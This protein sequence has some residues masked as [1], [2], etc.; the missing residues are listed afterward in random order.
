MVRI[1]AE[2]FV[3]DA[4]RVETRSYLGSLPNEAP[5]RNEAARSPWGVEN[6][7]PWVLDVT[8]HE[9]CSRSKKENAPEHFGLLRRL[10]LCLLKPE[11]SSKRSIKGKRLRASWD[12]GYLLQVLCGNA[13]N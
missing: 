4:P 6:A 10:A 1:E 13:E 11:S 2:R 5:V 7:L 8:F 9:D 3:G 12:D